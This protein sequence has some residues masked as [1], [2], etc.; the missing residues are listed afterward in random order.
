M[1]KKKSD[2]PYKNKSKKIKI[3]KTKY[4]KKLTKKSI[5]GF[6]D[7]LVDSSSSTFE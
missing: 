3:N 1:N 4:R 5:N 7:T 6:Q 2:Q